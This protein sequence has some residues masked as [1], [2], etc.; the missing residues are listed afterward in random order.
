MMFQ[1][2]LVVRVVQPFKD[3]DGE[4]VEA[5]EVLHFLDNNYFPYEGGVTLNFEEKTIRI[6]FDTGHGDI[7]ENRDNSWFE[8]V[9]TA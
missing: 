1:K 2:G 4:M 7:I 3:Y 8:P 9:K 5:G 6:A